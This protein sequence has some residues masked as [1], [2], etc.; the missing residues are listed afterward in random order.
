MLR[1]DRQTLKLHVEK[2]DFLQIACPHTSLPGRG[3]RGP[4][5]LPNA[6][7]SRLILL[8]FRTSYWP[9]PIQNACTVA[10][11]RLYIILAI[12]VVHWDKVYYKCFRTTVNRK[13]PC[14]HPRRLALPL[15]LLVFLATSARLD[16][17]QSTPSRPEPLCFPGVPDIVDCIEPL[18]RSYWERNGGLPVFGYPTGPALPEETTGAVRTVQPFERVRLEAHP[19]APAPYTVQLGRLG[20]ERL[21]QLN[22]APGPAV[23]PAGGCRF[24]APTG[25][26]VCGAFRI[27]W[28]AHGLDLSDQGI[29]ERES[30]ALL[31][32]PLTEAAVE[33]NSSG[34]RV[35]TQWFERVRLEQHGD[36]AAEARVLQGLLGVET[37]AALTPVAP[38]PGFVEVQGD[39]L[40]QQGQPIFLKGTNYYPAAHPWSYMWTRWDGPLVARELLRARR[41]LGINTV[42]AL[43]PYRYQEGW[44][45]RAGNL[46]PE[47]LD[48]LREFV[49]IAGGYQI[50]V[51]VTLFDWHDSVAAAGSAAEEADLR[52]LRTIV[53]AFKDDDR[54]LAWDLHNEPD[55]YPN[56]GAGRGA[57]VV[58]WLGRMADATR[59]ID[60]RHP[61]TVGVGRH[62]SLWLPAPNGRTIADISDIIS[63]HNYDAANFV[64][65]IEAVR[66]RTA[67]PLL[68]EEFG[69]ASGPECRGLYFDEPTQLY[70]YRQALKL[71]DR[72]DLV[73]MLG[74]WLQ[75]PPA[76]LSDSADENGHFGL[77]RRDGRPK[78]AIGPFRDLRVPAL[79]SS[80]MSARELTVVPPPA[81]PPVYQ[82]LVFDDGLVI[83]ES[84]K[85]FWNFFGGEAVFGRPL[86][87]AYRDQAGKLV[88]YFQRAR[89]ELNESEHVQP[90]DP[91]WAEGQTPEVY[92]DRVHLTPLGEQAAVGRTFARV[93]DPRRAEVRYFPQT[94]HTLSGAFRALWETRGEIFFGP[95]ISEAF[96]EVIDGRRTRVQYFTHW[97]FEQAGDGPVRLTTLGED[98]LRTRQ[99]PRP[100]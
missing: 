99:C 37:E 30:L 8:L 62:T 28:E 7:R 67:K 23:A 96:D 52:Y 39:K 49:Q 50:K 61:L 15:L 68:L 22:R 9:S 18:F 29:S 2:G 21:A 56:W 20:A 43:V 87:L 24:F 90:I 17:R 5:W 31:G 10:I 16:A 72:N 71:A 19:D 69:W 86:T 13:G 47:M 88:Q 75:D 80:T 51:I 85:H 53:D 46:R 35:L 83:L 70:M 65:M 11:V 59:A 41:E 26:N 94:G 64:P 14:M 77:Y 73:G 32:L 33:V 3:G 44:T 58:D 54:V 63:V 79:P 92:L 27:Y 97:R 93:A 76:T 84:F 48:R 34:D 78:P 74:W 38:R 82:P 25:H 95:P 57:E 91:D 36:S 81:V 40:V 42:R 55:N 45:D 98:A 60:R 6:Y 89:F 1:S 100:Y 12:T 4:D 66:A